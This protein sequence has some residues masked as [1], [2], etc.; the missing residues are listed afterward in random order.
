M[1]IAWHHAEVNTHICYPLTTRTLSCNPTAIFP[2]EHHSLLS[3]VSLSPFVHVDRC[4]RCFA[5]RCSTEAPD[6][7][8]CPLTPTGTAASILCPVTS[9]PPNLHSLV[10]SI[11]IR[12]LAREPFDFLA[13][14][15][16]LHPACFLLLL[17]LLILVPF[18]RRR[19]WSLPAIRARF[20]YAPR[21]RAVLGDG[22]VQDGLGQWNMPLG[23]RPSGRD[24]TAV[25]KGVGG[26]RRAKRALLTHRPLDNNK[27]ATIQVRE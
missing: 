14:H 18:T 11:L 27:K 24:H 19:L 10:A 1:F 5:W 21:W 9:F 25:R 15:E 6:R 2:D 20:A 26:R 12:F 23:C 17:L 13:V 7:A 4:L 22:P 16:A 8:A 3:A